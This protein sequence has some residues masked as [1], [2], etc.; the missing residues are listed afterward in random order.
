MQSEIVIRR[1]TSHIPPDDLS[2]RVKSM[3]G[4]LQ[5]QLVLTTSWDEKSRSVL[6]QADAGLAKGTNGYLQIGPGWI[7]LVVRLSMILSVQRVAVE[8]EINAV[9]DEALGR[10][11]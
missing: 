10:R 4:A 8:T 3:V 11:A 6:F 5:K 1:D 2:N 9:L 7:N